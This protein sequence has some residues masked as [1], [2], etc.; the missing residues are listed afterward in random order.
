MTGKKQQRSF[1]CWG[2]PGLAIYKIWQSWNQPY[3]SWAFDFFEQVYKS[4]NRNYYPVNKS[5]KS[6]SLESLVTIAWVKFKTSSSSTLQILQKEV[7]E[8]F[9]GNW[10]TSKFS[11]RDCRFGSWGIIFEYNAPRE[12]ISPLPTNLW[13]KLWKVWE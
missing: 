11:F 5:C 3:Y 12:L 1:S 2:E 8:G 9:V 4:F 10:Y 13:T 6:S 7:E